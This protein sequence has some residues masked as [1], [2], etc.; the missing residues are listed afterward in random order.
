[1][2]RRTLLSLAAGAA[3]GGL[4]ASASAAQSLTGK[5]PCGCGRVDVHAHYLPEPYRKALSDAGLTRVD[6]GVPIPSW[7]AADHLATMETLGVAVSMLSISSPGLHFLQGGEVSRLARSVNEAGA[8]IVAD[9][10]TRFGLLAALPLPDV[11]ASLAEIDYAFDELGV[12]GVAL[13]T[14][15][16][17]L[18]LGDPTFLPVFD[19]LE[20]R[21]AVVFLHPTSPECLS[22]IGMGFP[23]PLIE[24]PFDTA[25]T[26]V[27]VIFSGVLRQRPNIKVILPHGGGALPGLLSRIA[28]VSETPFIS[29]R[30]EGG[31]EEVLEQVRR[32]YFDLA[33]AAT[34]QNLAALLAVTDISHILFGTDYPFAP[35]PALASNTDGFN[36]LMDGLSPAARKMVESDNAAG[37]FPRL[38]AFL[39]EG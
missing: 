27:S 30:P 10:P 38:A 7:S 36:K 25:R 6:G 11:A 23:G 16:K 29:P 21:K 1:M 26:A 37:L 14:N 5:T 31:A 17:G 32:L 34:P 24:F 8:Q 33:L 20:R 9:N 35:P 12:D 15:A 22:Q 18:Y 2:M 39:R 3:V 19:A 4:T 28:M 13:E